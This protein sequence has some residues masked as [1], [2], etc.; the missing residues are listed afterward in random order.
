MKLILMGGP[1]GG[2]E[3]TMEGGSDDAPLGTVCYTNA[4]R[5]DEQGR[6]VFDYAGQ[7][8]SQGQRPGSVLVDGSNLGDLPAK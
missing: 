7:E 5:K 8:Y 4:R 3:I 2:G 1:L 6:W